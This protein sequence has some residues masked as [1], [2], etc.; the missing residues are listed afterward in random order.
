MSTSLPLDR[1]GLG[2]LSPAECLRRVRAAAVGRIAYIDDGELVI[3]PVNHGLDGDAVVFRTAPGAKLTA[4]DGELAMAFEVEEY[5]AALRTGSSVLI[6]GTAG[7]V[8][9]QEEVKRLNLLGVSPWA[10]LA[11]RNNWVR[12][13]PV[14]DARA[15]SPAPGKV[16]IVSHFDA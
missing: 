1:S 5:D 7:W 16:N 13:T 12:I 14:H 4:A 3:L 2:I 11:E 8:E 10:D 15:G 6:R 9:G